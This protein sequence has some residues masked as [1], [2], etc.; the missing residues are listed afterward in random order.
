MTP[1]EY[2]GVDPYGNTSKMAKIAIS[3]TAFLPLAKISQTGNHILSMWMFS[4]AD[5][6]VTLYYGDKNIE[7]N[8][9]TSWQSYEHKMELA[10][11]DGIYLELPA[12]TYYIWH[13]QLERATK[14]SDW[15]V[16]PEDVDA[17]VD[18]KLEK[19]ATLEITDDKISLVAASTQ[20]YTDNAVDEMGASVDAKLENYATLEVT[21]NKISTAVTETRTYTDGKANDAVSTAKSYTDQTAKSITSTVEKIEIGGRNLLLYSGDLTKWTKEKGVSVV[22][23]SDGWFKVVD[24]LHSA[25]RWG[26]YFELENYEQNTDYTLSV[27]VKYGNATI[28]ISQGFGDLGDWGLSIESGSKRLKRTINTG[29]NTAPIRVYLHIIPTATNQYGYFKLPKLEKG[30]KATDWT[31]AP[32]DISVE[33]IYTP[34]TT[35]I[36]GGKI[37]TGSIKAEKINVKDLFAQDITATG[38]ITGVTLE[39]SIIHSE[40]KR[41][42]DGAPYKESV[43]IRASTIRLISEYYGIEATISGCQ[44]SYINTRTAKEYFSIMED[45][46]EEIQLKIMDTTVNPTG[47]ATT[48]GYGMTK[49]STSVSSTS[50][51]LAATPSAVKT[52]YDKAKSA[53]SGKGLPW[54]VFSITQD[55]TYPAWSEQ[56][57]TLTLRSSYSGDRASTFGHGGAF[58]IYCPYSGRVEINFNF[59]INNVSSNGYLY[60]RCY[61]VG[62]ASDGGNELLDFTGMGAVTSSGAQA[63]GTLMPE[64]RGGTYIYIALCSSVAG[65]TNASSNT[66]DYKVRLQYRNIYD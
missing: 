57:P 22:K 19:Y 50:T 24:S 35:T 51:S 5:R 8:L 62:Y 18:V 59:L 28:G 26:I 55:I 48:D 40:S 44:F 4:N 1:Q 46:N 47:K 6:T 63:S 37:T 30:N 60:A 16:A 3:E 39:G 64:V 29:N 21:N 45:E 65:T 54:A 9:T 7:L 52:A 42:S 25:Y 14:K 13:A 2:I 32:E 15:V 17:S 53:F 61:G 10:V 27:D 41:I 58:Y 36:D 38:T 20:T 66:T 43:D 33:N 12:G 31:P 49:L 56:A 11:D 34:N 23:D